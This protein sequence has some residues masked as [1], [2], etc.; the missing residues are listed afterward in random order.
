MQEFG[1]I[2]VRKVRRQGTAELLEISL[3][4]LGRNIADH[5]VAVDEIL[6]AETKRRERGEIRK[7]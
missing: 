7:R 5:L 2:T 4:G 3:S 6:H 1:L